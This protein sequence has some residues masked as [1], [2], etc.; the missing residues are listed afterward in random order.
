MIPWGEIGNFKVLVKLLEYYVS[1][2]PFPLYTSS[3]LKMLFSVGGNI[4]LGGVGSPF[5][6]LGF[7]LEV[8]M[9]SKRGKHLQR[10]TKSQCV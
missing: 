3:P 1:S 8:S 7:L 5:L 9:L 2:S 4:D 10:F 6:P